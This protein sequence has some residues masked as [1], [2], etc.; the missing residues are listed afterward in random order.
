MAKRVPINQDELFRVADRLQA[1]GKEV[2]ALT[3]LA[4]LG[5]GSLTTIY[6]YLDLWQEAQPVV[7]SNEVLELPDVVKNSFAA[8]WRVAVAEAS[9]ELEAV[10]EKAREEVKTAQ[11]QFLG[12]LEAIAKLEKES[13][14]DAEQI[15]AL[16]KQNEELK[17]EGNKLSIEL[18]S[19]KATVDE[20]RQQATSGQIELERLRKE[21][22]RERAERDNAIREAAELKGK[23]EAMTAQNLEL[24]ELLSA[25]TESK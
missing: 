23:I 22:E 12:A 21:G 3:L 11:G 6:K 10:R 19:Q 8:A 5:G 1:E 18:A 9:R 14:A 16:T 24:M 25:C 15:E 4:A 2:T 13:E 7:R 17:A 20:L